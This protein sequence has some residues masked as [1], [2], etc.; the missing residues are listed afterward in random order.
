MHFI[1]ELV[2]SCALFRFKA[3]CFEGRLFESRF[4]AHFRVNLYLGDQFLESDFFAIFEIKV[5]F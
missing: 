4:L 2:T 3:L 1:L 5:F